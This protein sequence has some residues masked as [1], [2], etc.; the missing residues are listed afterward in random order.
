MKR[1]K[2]FGMMLAATLILAGCGGSNTLSGSGSIT[3]TGGGPSV[4]TLTAS[5]ATIPADGSANSTITATALDGNNV[6]VANANIVF[7]ASAGGVLQGATTTTDTNGKATA[8]LTAGSGAAAGTAITV[9]VTSGSTK[10]QTI[11]NVVANTQ[12]LSMTTDSPQ[13]PSDNSKVATIS[14]LLRDANNVAMSGVAITFAADSG[15][16]TPTQPT[17]D[18]SGT[19]K[20]TL[21]AG[22]DPTNRTITVTATGGSAA[23]ATIPVYVSGTTLAITGPA[24]LV[25]GANGTYTVLLTDSSGRGIPNKTVTVTS[26]NGNTVAPAMVTTDANGQGTI[27]L[28]ANSVA[29][30]GADTLTASSLGMLATCKL[31]VSS[32][33]FSITTPA[34]GIKVNLNTA[35]TVT[36]TW[37]S[38]GAAVTPQQTVNFSSTRGTLTPTSAMTDA[39][40]GQ[41]SVSIQSATAG[42]AV[43]SAS[44]NGVSAQIT[45]DFVATTPNQIAVQASPASVAV[46]TQS[47]ITAIVRDAQNNLVEGAT[48]TFSLTDSTGG[49]L[50]VPSAITDVQGRAQTIYTA[51]S[52]TSAANGVSVTA[53]VQG[54]SV[55]GTTTLTV[56]GQT[57]FLSLGTGNTIQSPDAATYAIQYA[58]LALD[59]HGAAVA[60]VPITLSVLPLS[61]VKGYRKWSSTTWTT[62]ATTSGS[63]PDASPP[64]TTNCAN[65]DTDYTGN[66]ASL[67]PANNTATC[68]DLVSNATIPSHK[69]DYN[70]NGVLDP[71]NVAAVA[72][73]SG[74]TGANGELLVTISYPK[75]HAYYVTV[76]LVATTTVAGTQDSA[77]STFLL[78]GST[79]DFNTQTTAPPGPVSPY[80]QAAVCSS[81]L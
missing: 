52:T 46:Q 27:T 69:K 55:S 45:I 40:T 68:T 19:A 34:N 33:N 24:N 42:P 26:A 61:Y 62:V 81:P 74:S 76:E 3:G 22:N 70:C 64:G 63:D 32:Q 39:T 48:V 14:A 11:V 9:T 21:S 72:P 77:S 47:T 50:S 2:T 58:V 5:T 23:A 49:S 29:N 78:P 44:G 13:V 6:A 51:G 75:D 20:A 38:G 17:T 7:A 18:A 1:F 54:T 71:G 65:E 79:T 60:N 37:L 36:A 4:A 41:A 53:T 43:I 10:G 28:T 15:V 66:I 35:Q 73:S 25:Q 67:D 12:T 31:T 8:T 56:G 30:G 16:L 59:S 80:G 57:V